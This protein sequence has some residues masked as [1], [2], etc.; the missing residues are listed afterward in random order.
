MSRVSVS[1]PVLLPALAGLI[2]AAAIVPSLAVGA[3]SV[4]AKAGTV[5]LTSVDLRRLVDALPAQGR[6]SLAGNPGA[7]AQ[8]VRGELLRRLILDEARAKGFDRDPSV[9]TEVD[10]LRDEI[11]VR[12][13][14]AHAAQPAVGYPSDEEI[15]RAHQALAERVAGTSDYRLAQVYISAPD[16]APSD[17]TQAALR[18][19]GEVQAKLGGDFSALAKT[20]SE[21][22]ESA[23]KG[24]DLGFLPESRLLPGVRAALPAMKVGDVAGPIKTAQGIHFI[25]L[26]EKKPASVPP[27]ADVREALVAE[28]RQEKVAD[29]QQ[30][31]LAELAQKS[32]PTL[33]EI[34]LAK[35]VPA[36]R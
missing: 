12:Q 8:A 2:L 34:E 19:A 7:L 6:Q 4:V 32:P 35:L 33:N 28:L 15:E 3:D 5:E 11:V 9:T 13:W 26:L 14:L 29:L 20:Y 16:G 10:K 25:R 1:P 30:R 21:H 22:A 17:K 36:A 27:L 18:K 24:G 31:Y 23:A